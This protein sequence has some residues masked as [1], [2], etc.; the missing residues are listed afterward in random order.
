MG[1]GVNKGGKSLVKLALAA[2]DATDWAIDGTVIC[3][4]RADGR[5][6]F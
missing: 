5:P 6:P 4:K 1:A 2:V 3:C